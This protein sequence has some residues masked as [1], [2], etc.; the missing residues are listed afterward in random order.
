MIEEKFR[1]YCKKAKGKD[2]RFCYYLGGV[3]DSATGI[4]SECQNHC[5][6]PCQQTKF[7][8]NLRKRII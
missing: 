5:H 4:L 1:Q 7:V 6:G 8:R 2:Q 3:E